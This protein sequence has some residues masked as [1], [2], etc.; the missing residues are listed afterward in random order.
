MNTKRKTSINWES[1]E[2]ISQNLTD[3]FIFRFYLNQY[4]DMLFWYCNNSFRINL[5]E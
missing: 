3:A 1:D 4:Y 5:L 2:S